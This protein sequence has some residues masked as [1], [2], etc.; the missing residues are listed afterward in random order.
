MR[1]RIISTDVRSEV[2][3][4][5][6]W[7]L[8]PKKFDE[9]VGQR[10]VIDQL[11][12]AIGAARQ[13]KDPLEHVLLDGPP[14][15]GKTTLAHVIAEEMGVA[16]RIRITSGPAIVKPGELMSTLTNLGEG[17]ILFVDEIHRLNKVV[18]EF[19]YPAMEDF[20]VDFTIDGGVGGR[21]VNF[22]LKRFTLI[23]ATT[24]A[25]MLSPAMRDRFGLRYHLDFYDA[26]DLT[27]ILGRSAKRLE[28]EAA[29]D[30]MAMI[31]ERSRGTPR[32]ANRLLKR[33]RDYAQVK[34]DGRITTA[35]V[36]QALRIEE[37]DGSGLDRLDRA[38]L[39][40]LI[41][42]YRGGPA[43]IEAIAATMG[44]S[45]DTLEDMVEPFL[46]QRSFITR[47]R[48]GRCAMPKAYTHLGLKAP[49]SH[50]ESGADEAGLF[51]A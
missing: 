18:E 19:L 41:E 7:A 42:T 25:G 43:G 51:D 44:Q 36:E 31:A 26:E 40:A 9:W 6:N 10:A 12:I 2:E 45:R 32:V 39:T 4:P 14:G 24:R 30:A 16:E 37:I 3:E 23:G 28:I 20:R 17:D 34:G 46:L 29:P 35:V 21:T 22:R 13:R 11:S 47:T 50:S 15:L 38:Y 1:D 5:S 8:R 33:I 49:A 27:E 48:Q